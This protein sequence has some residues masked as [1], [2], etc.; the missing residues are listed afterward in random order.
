ME[1]TELHKEIASATQNTKIGFYLDNTK[2]GFLD[3][4]VRETQLMIQGEYTPETLW[5]S[6]N[7]EWSNR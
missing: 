2:S 4:M 7:T 6:L 5:D 1:T 3:Y